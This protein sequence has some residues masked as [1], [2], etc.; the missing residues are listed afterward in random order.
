MKELLIT[1]S[2]P[3][4]LHDDALQKSSESPAQDIEFSSML[5]IDADGGGKGGVAAATRRRAWGGGGVPGNRVLL[6]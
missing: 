4:L 5:A 2:G 3:T 1:G 6:T